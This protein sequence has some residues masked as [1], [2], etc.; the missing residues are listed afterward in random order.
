MSAQPTYK[1]TNFPLF[2][3]LIKEKWVQTGGDFM[4]TLRIFLRKASY[5][6]PDHPRVYVTN[7]QLFLD[8]LIYFRYAISDELKSLIIDSLNQSQEP[9]PCDNPPL[10]LE[11]NITCHVS[12][13]EHLIAK[14]QSMQRNDLI[15]TLHL[16]EQYGPDYQLMK[17]DYKAFVNGLIRYRSGLPDEDKLLSTLRLAEYPAID[18]PQVMVTDN[19]E[20]MTLIKDKYHLSPED[21]ELVFESLIKHQQPFE[22]NPITL[23]QCDALSELLHILE[24]KYMPAICASFFDTDAESIAIERIIMQTMPDHIKDPIPTDQMI[25]QTATHFD[26]QFSPSQGNQYPERLNLLTEFFKANWNQLYENINS[27]YNSL[28][29][30]YD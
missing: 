6:H 19:D 21:A 2:S 11:Q 28:T 30:G 1:I 25:S 13:L 22:G 14:L 9:Y 27:E 23:H 24:Y 7:N 3:Q 15:S 5:R 10:P 8:D 17:T 12:F 26:E 16:I 18:N 29:H 20:F 4:H